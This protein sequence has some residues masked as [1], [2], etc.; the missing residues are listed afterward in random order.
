LRGR[1]NRE[2]QRFPAPRV[3]KS[4]GGKVKTRF[5]AANGKESR[6]FKEK[7]PVAGLTDC[8]GRS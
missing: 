1:M 3:V 4:S 8:R 6:M 2:K 5:L 7:E